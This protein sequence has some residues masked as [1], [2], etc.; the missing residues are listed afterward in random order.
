M[1]ES[2]PQNVFHAPVRHRIRKRDSGANGE[3]AGHE[4]IRTFPEVWYEHVRKTDVSGG[5]SKNNLT[6]IIFL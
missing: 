5:H 4:R 1:E 2:N 6:T 3:N